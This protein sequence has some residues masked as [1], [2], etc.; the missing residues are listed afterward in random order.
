MVRARKIH[1]LLIPVR[2]DDPLT[3]SAEGE[4]LIFNGEGVALEDIPAAI[5]CSWIVGTPA[6]VPDG[7]VVEIILPHGA[8]APEET[9]FP[10]SILISQDG[11]V[12]LPPFDPATEETI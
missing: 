1:L 9:R 11:P 7:W 2:M 5:A 10:A 12:N 3:I 6:P 4:T 8:D